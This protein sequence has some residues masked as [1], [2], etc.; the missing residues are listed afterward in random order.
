MTEH[1]IRANLLLEYYVQRPIYENI[2]NVAK[3][4]IENNLI[5]L[6]L[7]KKRWERIELSARIKEFESAFDKL[8]ASKEANELEPTDS[9]LTLYDMAA[10]KIRVFPNSYLGPVKRIV[11]R[12]FDDVIEDHEPNKSSRIDNKTYF[13][14]VER[15]KF[16]VKLNPRFNINNRFEIQVVPFLLDAFM[17][18]EHDTIYKPIGLPKEIKIRMKHYRSGVISN[19]INF[20]KEFENILRE[21]DILS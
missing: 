1:E 18:V 6:R 3:A 7:K 5:K 13:A 17:D 15:L 2:I 19:V 9:L 12:L 10:L 11:M 21:K 8:K 14:D 16:F 4:Q 20:S